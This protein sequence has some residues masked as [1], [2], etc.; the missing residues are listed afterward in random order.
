MERNSTTALA[1]AA[2]AGKRSACKI[3]K[4]TSTVQASKPKR[5]R[6]PSRKNRHSQIHTR[7]VIV[8]TNCPLLIKKKQLSDLSMARKSPVNS[9]LHTIAQSH[10]RRGG[11]RRFGSDGML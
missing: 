2:D 3:G 11:T 10:A 4:V 5:P 6:L 9:V 1:S 7:P 8:Q